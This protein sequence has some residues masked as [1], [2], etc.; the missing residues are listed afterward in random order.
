MDYERNYD[1]PEQLPGESN[2]DWCRRVAEGI[3]AEEV[4][5]AMVL[6]FD[7]ESRRRRRSRLDFWSRIG[8]AM[9]HGSGVSS[10]IAERFRNWRAR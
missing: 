9:G 4:L 6:Y 7:A 5:H 8:E 3:P 1:V 10:A 2:Q